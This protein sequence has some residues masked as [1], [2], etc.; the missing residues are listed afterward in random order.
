MSSLGSGFADF[1]GGLANLGSAYATI[2]GVNENKRVNDLNFQLQKENL[3]YQ[4]D[5][6]NIIFGREDNAVQR[7]VNDLRKAGLSPTLAAG[8]AAGAGSVVS[9]SAPQRVS[10][11]QGYL[12]LAQIGT[13][14]ATQQKARTEADIARQSLLQSKIDTKSKQ[15]DYKYLVNKGVAPLE[16]NQ[17]WQQRLV[18][19]IYP[20]LEDWMFGDKDKG[21]EGLASKIIE[22]LTKKD[23]VDTSNYKTFDKD[24]PRVKLANGD[25]LNDHEYEIMK[26]KGL[27]DT[28]YTTGWTKYLEQMVYGD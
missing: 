8:S 5:L 2:K 3:A 20:K 23:S 26:K 22:S 4:K 16:V 19:L 1:A 13:M 11:L 17:D 18:N 9:T 28:F 14:L 25:T 27:L 24:I 15:L 6:Q 21:K 12:A 10:D 7:R